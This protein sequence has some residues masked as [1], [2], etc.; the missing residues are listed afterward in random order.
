MQQVQPGEC[1]QALGG[2]PSLD[3]MHE[4][5]HFLRAA[6]SAVGSFLRPAFG[7]RDSSPEHSVYPILRKKREGWGGYGMGHPDIIGFWE[8]GKSRPDLGLRVVHAVKIGYE[9][10]PGWLPVQLLL[11]KGAGGR[12]VMAGEVSKPSEVGLGLLGLDA[13][14]R[15]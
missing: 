9:A 2:P 12:H 3:S 10:R 11:G 6:C 7:I 15:Q 14:Y 5:E 4:G 13:D 8:R 1:S